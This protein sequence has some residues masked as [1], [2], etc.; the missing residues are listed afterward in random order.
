MDSRWTRRERH[1]YAPQNT[2]FVLSSS[3]CEFLQCF[4]VFRF[5][6]DAPA[7]EPF[8]VQEVKR[9]LFFFNI[10]AIIIDAIPL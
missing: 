7:P 5:V 1:S 2:A 3:Y 9:E 4:L 10:V 8:L 6:M